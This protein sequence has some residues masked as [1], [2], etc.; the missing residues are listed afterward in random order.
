MVGGRLVLTDASGSA[1]CCGCGGGGSTGPCCDAGN[2]AFIQYGFVEETAQ[3]GV[4]TFALDGTHTVSG[5]L[6]WQFDSV[7]FV[8]IQNPTAVKVPVSCSAT[9]SGAFTGTTVVTAGFNQT[10][11]PV[12]CHPQLFSELRQRRDPNS[13][14]NKFVSW[15]FN[16]DPLV[17]DEGGS[18]FASVSA[19]AS[20]GSQLDYGNGTNSR[21][22]NSL[23]VL[24]TPEADVASVRRV[25]LEVLTESQVTTGLRGGTGAHVI[26]D[27]T[28]CCPLPT[29]VWISCAAESIT[30]SDPENSAY[31]E[32]VLTDDTGT[33][34]QVNT[35]LSPRLQDWGG[36]LN[37]SVSNQYSDP[38]VGA[39]LTH[40]LR[41]TLDHSASDSF[42]YTCSVVAD[43]TNVIEWL[44][45][46][47]PRGAVPRVSMS[48]CPS[49]VDR[50]R[51]T[52][53]DDGNSETEIIQ[54]SCPGTQ[55]WGYTNEDGS[56]VDISQK[57]TML[58]YYRREVWG[59]TGLP[60]CE[61]E[62]L[63][64]TEDSFDSPQPTFDYR[65]GLG[66][67]LSC[68]GGQSIV[69][70]SWRSGLINKQY[71]DCD[72]F[73]DDPT[74]QRF[75]TAQAFFQNNND[76]GTLSLAAGM[77]NNAGQTPY[78]V[79]QGVAAIGVRM[80]SSTSGIDHE[81]KP[82]IEISAVGNDYVATATT[83]DAWAWQTGNPGQFAYATT[84][85]N[86]ATVYLQRSGSG[87]I[88]TNL[89]LTNAVQGVLIDIE[90]SKKLIGSANR[91]VLGARVILFFH[92][93]TE[94]PLGGTPDIDQFFL[95]N[96]SV[97]ASGLPSCVD[98]AIVSTSRGECVG[99]GGGTIPGGEFE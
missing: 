99:C 91:V 40:S 45:F 98:P 38:D 47:A 97:N 64:S 48:H 25:V 75:Y 11:G 86:A 78:A 23:V 10:V 87:G 49:Y 59:P 53:L 12:Y 77:L 72:V 90:E 30:A 92:P 61:G 51:A 19:P 94:A 1:P 14:T 24:P 15:Q 4:G 43:V 65:H 83:Y 6:S 34:E 67:S 50:L 55:G 42:G 8:D 81:I 20:S 74:L 58:A 46:G 57:M 60:D 96:A 29:R 31:W 35:T 73:T 88:G 2:D 82:V 17:V 93:T 68:I 95:L 44:E 33:Y 41:Y 85:V 36:T 56:G 7:E 54:S 69:V 5:S 70:P 84:T 39:S 21:I 79:N 76:A 27:F 66:V 62:R 63:L 80:G 89:D 37:V 22:E 9:L 26:L 28:A 16:G 52:C 18:G 3:Q 32:Y 71:T 13:P